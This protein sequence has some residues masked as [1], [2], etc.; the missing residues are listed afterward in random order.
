MQFFICNQDEVDSKLQTLTQTGSSD[1]GWTHHYVDRDTNEQWILTRYHSENQGGGIPVLKRLP[2]LTIDELI[3]IA[4]TSCDKNDIIGASIELSER[5]RTKKDDF[6]NKLV[7]R[8]MMVDTS[9][10]DRF[11]K[12]RLKIIIQESDLYDATNRREIVG[13]HYSEIQQDADY[14]STVAQKATEILAEI[15]KYSS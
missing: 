12:Q 9:K 10:L 5:E 4:L 7:E 1:D 3:D 15:E 8:L 2:E 14:Y 11:E 13:K 6:R